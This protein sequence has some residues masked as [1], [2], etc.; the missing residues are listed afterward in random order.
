[1]AAPTFVAEYETAWNNNTN[2]KVTDA[3]NAQAGDL[4]V[5]IGMSE[6]QAYPLATP[7]NTQG[8]LTWTL[9]QSVVVAAYSTVYVWTATVDANKTGMTVSVGRTGGGWH[10][11]NVVHW[12]GSSGIGASAKANASGAPSVSLTTTQADSAVVVANADWNALATARTWRT[13]GVAATEVSYSATGNYTVY[14]AYHSNAGPAGAKTAGL[15][16]P[17]GQKYSIVAVEVLGTASTVPSG[18][19]ALT[20]TTA[21]D[22]AGSTTR[23]GTAAFNAAAGVAATGSVDRSGTAGITA[24]TDVAA[25]GH[26][27]RSGTT[28]TSTTVA[29]SAS[30]STARSGTAAFTVSL[31]VT[32]IGELDMRDIVISSTTG[33]TSDWATTLLLGSSLTISPIVATWDTTTPRIAAT[34]TGPVNEST[35]A[36]GTPALAA[37][38][39]A[40]TVAAT[41]TSPTN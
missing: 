2:P 26:T 4:L 16:A 30:G 9:R 12:R 3:F 36:I 8:A 25:A 13:V 24:G 18:S 15:S 22:T 21:L 31:T 27:A 5:C 32:A 20:A 38:V 33:P 11:I 7:T 19:A 39:N 10:G 29:L 34:T 6:D 41:T 17:T 23:T 40:P 14:A 28:D 35:I 1:M 37:T